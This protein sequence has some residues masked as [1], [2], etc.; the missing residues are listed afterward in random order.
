MKLNRALDKGHFWLKNKSQTLANRH[1]L[2]AAMTIWLRQKC[3]GWG[4]GF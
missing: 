1:G 4:F 3:S 2:A